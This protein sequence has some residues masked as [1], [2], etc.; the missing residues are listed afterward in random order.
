[1]VRWAERR[2]RGRPRHRKGNAETAGRQCPH[3]RQGTAPRQDGLG[4]WPDC[5][6]SGRLTASE[7]R[8]SRCRRGPT[9][10]IRGVR[11]SPAQRRVMAA[12][13][14]RDMPPLS[15][16]PIRH[17]RLS[18]PM[19]LPSTS[20]PAPAAA[21]AS[22]P[23]SRPPPAP[24]GPQAP[25]GP[26]RREG[27]P[28]S[29]PAGLG[30]MGRRA[31]AGI[32][33]RRT[34]ARARGRAAGPGAA[35]AAAPHCA[36]WAGRWSA[37]RHAVPRLWA[38][39]AAAAVLIWGCAELLGLL[40]QEWSA[41]TAWARMDE[42]LAATLRARAGLPTLTLFARLT[43][44]GDTEVLAVL[45]VVVGD[46]AV[47]A[48]PPAPG[49]LLGRGPSGQR[50]AHPRVQARL[51]TGAA[52]AYARRL[53]GRRLQLPERAQQQLDGRL[54]HA[55]L[56]GRAPAAGALAPPRPCSRQH[57]WCSRSAG[58]GW[59]CRCTTRATCS[60][61]GS[62]EAPGWSAACW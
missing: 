13:G 37:P 61:A 10:G 7:G 38:A 44:A 50:T 58:A 31:P 14:A 6:V 51:R 21:P 8:G 16:L 40:A 49:G 20:R 32:L 2:G 36:P 18:R 25:A 26:A 54:R 43:H 39:L 35:L 4:A 27:P 45:A 9:A 11:E 60:R 59:C 1:M 30:G 28:M 46:R 41:P 24:H 15:A 29:A 12:Q 53:G 17:R 33:G 5:P 19:H 55:G 57:R 42:T 52:G 23:S 47:V 56:S 34:V 62:P 3:G 22:G 48:P